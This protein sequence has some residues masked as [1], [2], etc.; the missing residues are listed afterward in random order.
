[1][2]TT[3]D[4]VSTTTQNNMD[5]RKNVVPPTHT[6]LL[7]QLMT[8]KIN[9]RVLKE[10]DFGTSVKTFFS[11]YFL[12]LAHITPSTYPPKDLNPPTLI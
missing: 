8:I 12:L 6:L 1:M 10:H 11:P 7:P 3:L 5:T 9:G 4:Q 2:Q